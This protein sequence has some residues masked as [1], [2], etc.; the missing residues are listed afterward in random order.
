MNSFH[1]IV[2]TGASGMVGHAL[3]ASFQRRGLRTVLLDRAKCDIAN[4]ADIDR[5][6]HEHRP[7]LLLNCAAHTKVDLCEDEPEK[8]NLINGHAVGRLAE[9]A[10]EFATYLVHYSTD[11]VFDG[12]S[13]R[14]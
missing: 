13:T 2:I 8:A 4:P 11:F 10:R 3:A 1:S 12:T 5:L 14:P 9:R 6:F 7:T